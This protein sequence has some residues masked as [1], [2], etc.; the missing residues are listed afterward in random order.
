VATAP[1]VSRWSL[2]LFGVVALILGMLEKR[3][4][5]SEQP[6]D[7]VEQARPVIST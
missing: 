7:S 3:L 2:I 5:R 1:V 6:E 4:E